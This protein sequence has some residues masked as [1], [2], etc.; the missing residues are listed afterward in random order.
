MTPNLP[1]G[2]QF[3]PSPSVLLKDY[4]LK[5]VLG[6]QLPS[7][8]VIEGE[9]YG[10]DAQLPEADDIGDRE[11][12]KFVK[13][14]KNEKGTKTKR[15]TKNGYWKVTGNKKEIKDESGKHTIGTMRSLVLVETNNSGRKRTLLMDEYSLDG[16]LKNIINSEGWVVCKIKQSKRSP[17]RP[18]SQEEEEGGGGG[19]GGG[20]DGLTSRPTASPAPQ[21]IDNRSSNLVIDERHCVDMDVIWASM[22][23][24]Q[25]MDQSFDQSSTMMEPPALD[26]NWKNDYDWANFVNECLDYTYDPESQA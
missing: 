17:E 14:K 13:N 16:S 2:F 3:N 11:L 12:Y 26:D 19:G 23:D 18:N 9:V 22:Q 25:A 20:Y 15:M 7:D 24:N 21:G 4:L 1:P 8:A 5:K 6:V 10:G